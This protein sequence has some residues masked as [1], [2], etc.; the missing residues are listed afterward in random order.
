MLGI[1]LAAQLFGI[2][3]AAGCQPERFLAVRCPDGMLGAIAGDLNDLGT[4]VLL[5][6]QLAV[7]PMVYAALFIA[8]RLALA[9][10]R[11]PATPG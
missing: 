5:A 11:E 9:L 1:G 8:V 10:L 3:D 6:P 7:L 2:A 4:I